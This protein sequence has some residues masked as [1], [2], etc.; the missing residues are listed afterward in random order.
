MYILL[1]ILSGCE[2]R[3]RDKLIIK[4]GVY[5]IGGSP[6]LI[7]RIE[8]MGDDRLMFSLEGGKLQVS[9]VIEFSG[10]WLVYSESSGR[11]WYFD[12]RDDLSVML[13]ANTTAFSTSVKAEPALEQEI[14]EEIWAHL[15]D[16]LKN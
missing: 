16:F 12:G 6:Q 5:N 4:P 14:P 7:V 10:N 13:N 2:K 1:C 8:T 9:P 11:V 15:P 3:L